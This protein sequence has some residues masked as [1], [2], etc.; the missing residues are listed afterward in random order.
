MAT[1]IPDHRL[2]V[3]ARTPQC[4]P[5]REWLAEKPRTYE[6]LAD[7]PEWAFIAAKVPGSDIARLAA[8]VAAHGSPEL[9]KRFADEIPGA[10]RALLLVGL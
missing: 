2:A 10:D 6:D 4:R 3:H 9:R 5:V 8:V 1:L 7:H